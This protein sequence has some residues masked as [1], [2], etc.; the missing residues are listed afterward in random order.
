MGEEI[1]NSDSKGQL[2]GYQEHY[3]F[4]GLWYRTNFKYGL[5]IGY[6]E[7]HGHKETNFYII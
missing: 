2:H 6:E 7:W 3:L 5:E 4:G 1:E